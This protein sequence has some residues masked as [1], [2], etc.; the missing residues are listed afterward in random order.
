MEDLLVM[1]VAMEMLENEDIRADFEAFSN[2]VD[3]LMN[4]GMPEDIALNYVAERWTCPF[5]S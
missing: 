1:M 2:E 3:R 5:L 4:M